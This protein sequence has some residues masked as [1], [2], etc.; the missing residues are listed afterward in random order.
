MPYSLEEGSTLV[1]AARSTIELY[2]K[3]PR[4]SRLMIERYLQRFDT[5]SG[6]FVTLEHYPTMT[7]RGCIG[8][9]N[10]IGPLKRLLVEAAIAAAFEDPRFP[11]ISDHELGELVIEVSVLT[12]PEHI[13]KST[14]SGRL[15]EIKIGRDGL[16]INYGFKSGLLLPIV[17]V[18]ELWNKEEFLNNLCLKA[19]LPEDA[20]KRP[21]I[22]LY[23]FSTQV[24]KEKEPMGTVEEVPLD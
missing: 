9:P 23:K 5:S 19:G 18:H 21:E 13:D 11:P 8:F 2:L 17:A 12:K 1:K 7:L 3:S 22:S 20:W 15:K 4:F 10:P 16:M 14:V 24:F 6:V